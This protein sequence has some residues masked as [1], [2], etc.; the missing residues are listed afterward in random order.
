MSDVYAEIEREWQ[1]VSE[2]KRYDMLSRREF[3]DICSEYET[4]NRT[5]ALT[6]LQPWLGVL[7]LGIE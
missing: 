2:R 1:S 4:R 3:R 5:E 6:E 7:E